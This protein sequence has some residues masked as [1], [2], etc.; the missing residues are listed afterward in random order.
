MTDLTPRT[1]AV[2]YGTAFRQLLPNGPAWPKDHPSV[3]GSVIDG[4]SQELQR[5]DDSAC[6]LLVDVFPATTTNFVQEWLDTVGQSTCISSSLTL[7]QARS[8]II[9]RL[10]WT[11]EMSKQFYIAYAAT[12]GYQIDIIEWSGFTCGL[13][14]VGGTIGVSSSSDIDF[15]ITI[16]NLTSDLDISVLK[17][18][19]EP[20]LPAYISVYWCEFSI[21]ATATL[22][23][24]SFS[25]LSS[26]LPQSLNTQ[27]NVYLSRY[28]DKITSVSYSTSSKTA[29]SGFD[30]TPVS[31]TA[32]IDSSGSFSFPISIMPNYNIDDTNIQFSIDLSIGQQGGSIINMTTPC[33]I[34]YHSIPP[35]TDT[36]KVPFSVPFTDT[37]PRLIT[38]ETEDG[39]AVAGV[40]YTS[41]EDGVLIPPGWQTVYAKIPVLSSPISESPKQFNVIFKWYDKTQPAVAQGVAQCGGLPIYPV[42]RS[43]VSAS[44]ASQ[45]IIDVSDI[46]IGATYQTQDGTAVAGVD[47]VATNGTIS[48]TSLDITIRPVSPGQPRRYFYLSYVSGIS[49][50]EKL[51][52]IDPGPILK[53]TPAPTTVNV[54][55]VDPGPCVPV[56]TVSKTNTSSNPFVIPL[57]T[58]T[59]IYTDIVA[60]NEGSDPTY[61]MTL[62]IS[63][64]DCSMRN[65]G[66]YFQS[67][68]TQVNDSTATLTGTA[69]EITAAATMMQFK[70]IQATSS[71]VLTFTLTGNGQTSTATYNIIGGASIMTFQNVPTANNK[72]T[73]S[74]NS[75]SFYDHFGAITVANNDP[76]I[77]MTYTIEPDVGGGDVVG[78]VGETVSVTPSGYGMII[79]ANSSVMSI[80]MI[81]FTLYIGAGTVNT[82]T[83]GDHEITLT[84]SDGTNTITTTLPYTISI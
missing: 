27:C 48:S 30:F 70:P 6:D 15:S 76:Y 47:Y 78:M 39:S 81:P 60:S 83:N 61:V 72:P 11:G 71:T 17:C 22:D 54:T 40:D 44:L 84:C 33:S 62:T 41:T 65:F 28:L 1:T 68:Y 20:I 74:G 36:L 26:P 77:E 59:A 29:I 50:Q 7:E 55:T 67:I 13:S 63:A 16:V 82:V 12:L 43:T 10:T 49:T 3:M 2:Q 24:T 18:F 42:A 51:V 25:T 8:Q 73:I 58:Y 32:Q 52:V 79:N 23:Q 75:F 35:I 9:S 46:P 31:G 14:Q 45:K 19:F 64:T 57:S 37:I 5:T 56:M 53:A 80:V 66:G 34:T 21:S 69:A 38:W 4:L